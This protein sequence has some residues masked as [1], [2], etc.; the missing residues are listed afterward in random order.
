MELA[1]YLKVS[2]EVIVGSND[3]GSTV[4]VS[5]QLGIELSGLVMS[6]NVGAESTTTATLITTQPTTTT[7]TTTTSAADNHNDNHNDSAA[8][9][10]N[11]NH[12]EQRKYI[13][14][15]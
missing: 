10:N 4:N 11:D 2:G 1:K 9:N 12:N 14:C 5:K 3:H 7:T 8:D 13:Q 15:W 6:F